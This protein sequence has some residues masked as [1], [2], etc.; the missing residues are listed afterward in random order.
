MVG[1][2]EFAR[3]YDGQPVADRRSERR[4]RFLDAGVAVFGGN[5]YQGSSVAGICAAAGL[6]RSQFYEQFANREEL[7]LA[8]YDMIRT[9]TRNAVA[10]AVAK[11]GQRSLADR[12]RAAIAAYV[13]SI[14][15]DPRRAAISFVEIVGISPDVERHRIKRRVEWA[16]F[17]VDELTAVVGGEV[18]PPGGY[19]LI[20][21]G[22]IGA[23]MSLVHQWSTSTPRTD[24]TELTEVLVGFLS[25]FLRP[26]FDE[27][28]ER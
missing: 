15:Q 10:A 17:F 28:A 4:Q 7:M 25:G 11:S 16:Q 2:R 6:A 19:E 12:V 26:A 18:E 13:A 20:A 24:L 8:V 1:P 23:L 5:G 27:G 22:F 3:T 9:D 21:T 14:G